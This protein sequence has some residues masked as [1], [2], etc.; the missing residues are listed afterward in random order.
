MR[1]MDE[2][3]SVF[4]NG[5]YSLVLILLGVYT[6][7]QIDLNLTL[8]S[9][10]VYQA[11]QNKL[12]LLGYYQR[13]E[14]AL[15]F[16]ILISLFFIV[17]ILI[18]KFNPKNPQTN[19]RLLLYTLVLTAVFG[20]ISYPA[21]SHD[22]FN[23]LFDARIVT[24]YHQNPYFYKALD[25]P[26]DLWTRFMHW[27]HRTYPYGPLWLLFT[28]P[29]SF[30]GRGKFVLTLILFKLMFAG[31]YLL[32]I[33]LIKD[34]ISGID[35]KNLNSQ[36]YFFALNPLIII[37]TLI[38]PHNESLML[39]FLLFSY[40]SLLVYKQK[41]WAALWLLASIGVKFI[42]LLLLPLLFLK[43]QKLNFDKFI[44]F[45]VILLS[46]PLVI[47]I[48]YREAY[49]WYFI[50]VI[51]VVAL[52][53]NYRLRN[54]L[55]AISF[56]ALLR[57]LPFLATGEYSAYLGKQMNLILITPPLI[58]LFWEIIKITKKGKIEG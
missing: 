2:L 49:P 28:L 18:L 4:I 10:P 13:F 47:E 8:S 9:N 12:I 38:S 14:S 5:L 25:F 20:I 57:Y 1:S 36:L 39:L 52:S 26:A 56:G 55:T 17:Y 7:T 50:P 58:Y 22:L 46:I 3:F 23:Y 45:S 37:E 48:W 21:F 29:F 51:G 6:Y 31:I 24:K 54:L 43:N 33:K 44:L 16:F 41:I 27:T 30:L 53:Q 19:K 34:I 32:N 40:K 35:K 15:I 42:T 11:V